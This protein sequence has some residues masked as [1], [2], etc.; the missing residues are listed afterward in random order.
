MIPE[1][2]A[3]S[4]RQL[5]GG[6][7]AAGEAPQSGGTEASFEEEVEERVNEARHVVRVGGVLVEQVERHA[8]A[9]GLHDSEE[10]EGELEQ[11]VG[12]DDHEQR[13]HRLPLHPVRRPCPS[14]SRSP[15]TGQLHHVDATLVKQCDEEDEHAEDEDDAERDEERAHRRDDVVL[16][17][18]VG[19]TREREERLDADVAEVHN[20]VADGRDHPADGAEEP[21]DRLAHVAVVDERVGDVHVLYDRHER[22][23]VVGDLALPDDERYEEAT[24]RLAER[25]FHRREEIPPRVYEEDDRVETVGQREVDEEQVVEVFAQ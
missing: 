23:H 15:G 1:R 6:V 25:P 7:T 8:L 18:H 9:Q 3:S 5:G 14:P 20:H 2:D 10:V 16:V 17:G 4:R 12:G 22:E 21:N 24:R 11:D 19:E 13:A